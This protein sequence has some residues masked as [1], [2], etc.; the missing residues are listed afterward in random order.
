VQLVGTHPAVLAGVLPEGAARVAVQDLRDVWHEAAT[1]R[2]AWL[3]ALPHE[4]RGPTPPVV[5]RAAD[6]RPLSPPED[7]PDTAGVLFSVPTAE[8]ADPVAWHAEQRDEER[9]VLEAAA[10]LLL[11]VP[12]AGAPQ[13]GG[14]SHDGR[15]SVELVGDGIAVQVGSEGLL[16][17]LADLL[18]EQLPL[19]LRDDRLIARTVLEA[20]PTTVPARVD[21]RR[22]TFTV[23]AAGGA[24]A[25]MHGH[26]IAV[27]GVGPVPEE[28]VLV[29]ISPDDVVSDW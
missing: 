21:G 15:S 1:A 11:W 20:T 14:W 22:V 29:R 27:S 5:F 3:C 18:E 4:D 9:R 28:L 24:W 16:V 25:A 19:V 23:L 17:E 7:E 2:G 6:G 13:L 12:G 10:D 8:R 26:T